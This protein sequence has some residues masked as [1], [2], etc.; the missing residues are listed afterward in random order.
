MG[1]LKFRICAALLG[2]FVCCLSF[3]GNP[4]EVRFVVPENWPKPA[5]DFAKNPLTTAGFQL[6]RQLFYDPLLSRDTTISCASCHL[7]ATGFAHVDHNLSHGIAGRI[8]KRNAPAI[9][10]MAWSR[11]FMWDGGVNHLDVQPLSPITSPD[12]MDETMDHVV[13]KLNASPQYRTMYKAAFN[14]SIATGQKTLMALS[15]FVVMLN[16]YNAR[17]DKYMRHE[18]GGELTA[19]ELN[20]LALF[21]KN[22]ASCH[23][24][25]L[26]TT[27]EFANNG[28][29]PDPALLDAGRMKITGDPADSLTFKVPTLRNIQFTYP[30]MHDGR[31]K[32]LLE[33]VN[34]YTNG[35]KP[36]KNLD[37]R[38]QTP[39]LLSPEEKID[40]VAFLLTLTDREFLFDPRFGYPRK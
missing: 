1:G 7:Q 27:G 9:L 15:Q 8:G 19:Q 4:D 25:P 5:Y 33:V 21:R 16:S 35:I 34:H 37:K 23:A 10:N 13:R 20:G 30:Y 22:C 32:K 40:L 38:L 28:L 36:G 24:E 31:F 17:Y 12:E 29:P 11:S 18:P 26:F 14:D 39:I 2:L 6:G 3:T